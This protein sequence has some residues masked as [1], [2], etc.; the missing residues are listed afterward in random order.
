MD[1]SYKN[2]AEEILEELLKHHDIKTLRGIL[3]NKVR[4]K[5][6][7]GNNYFKTAID[8][9]LKQ[10]YN[11]SKLGWA[12][13]QIAES[14]N[15]SDKTIKNHITKFRK[16]IKK[17]IGELNKGSNYDVNS[18]EDVNDF[19]SA[20]LSILEEKLIDEGHN[21]C[22]LSGSSTK[23]KQ[24]LNQFITEINNPPIPF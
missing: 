14:A 9:Y 6:P 19:I 23:Y 2:N 10:R 21:P 20:Y 13:D 17:E 3:N 8:V 1:L 7:R 5:E 12:I 18:I 16:E 22:H 11:E 15:I 24:I 4:K